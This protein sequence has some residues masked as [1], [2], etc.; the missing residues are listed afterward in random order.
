MGSVIL[1]FFTMLPTLGAW[2]GEKHREKYAWLCVGGFNFAGVVHYLI[3]LWFGNHTAEGA[4]SMLSEATVLVW[5][6]GSAGV[7]WMFYL[8]IPPMITS[9]VNFVTGRKTSGL[10]AAQKKLATE[11]GDEVMEKE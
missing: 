9:W 5:A 6:Y 2:A 8:F 7:G 3:N 10:R 11:W 4:F 1:L